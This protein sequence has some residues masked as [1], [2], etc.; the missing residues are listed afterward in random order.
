MSG[1]ADQL[2]SQLGS[3]EKDLNEATAKRLDLMKEEIRLN[4]LG[5][6]A[7][8]NQQYEEERKRLRD[9]NLSA[10]RVSQ[11]SRR[12]PPRSTRRRRPLSN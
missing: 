9:A 10:S 11:T 2:N 3:V 4:A 1:L 12:R 6:Q 8:I 7:E 5:A